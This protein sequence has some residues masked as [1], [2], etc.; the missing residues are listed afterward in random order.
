MSITTLPSGGS[1]SVIDYRCE[2]RPGDHALAEWHDA[3]SV[4]YVK[5]PD[6]RKGRPAAQ[7]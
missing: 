3:F 1:V 4:S 2:A 5:R 7:L 6:D